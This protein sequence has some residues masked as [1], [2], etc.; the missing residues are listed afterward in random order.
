MWAWKYRE[1]VLDMFE[2]ISGNR[3]HYGM[4]KIGG[5][6][7]DIEHSHIS[8]LKKTLNGLVPAIDMF[9]GAVMDDP[10]IQARLKA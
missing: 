5:V 6:R 4:S 9:K 1:P 2:M 7:R 3:N 8:A 10:V